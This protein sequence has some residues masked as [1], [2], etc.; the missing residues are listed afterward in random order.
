MKKIQ[1]NGSSDI[2]FRLE[3]CGEGKALFIKRG[4]LGQHIAISSLYNLICMAI[5]EMDLP[6]SFRK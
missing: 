6:Q 4:R 3:L 5:L 1:S 2:C